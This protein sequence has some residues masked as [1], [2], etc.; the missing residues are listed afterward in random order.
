LLVTGWSYRYFARHLYEAL[1]SQLLEEAKASGNE[2]KIPVFYVAIFDKSGVY[3][4][5]LTP[6]VNEKALADQDL[7]SKTAGGPYQGVLTITDR[8]FGFGAV[9][10]PKLAPDTGVVVMRSEL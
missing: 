5:P 7:V 8:S 10:T 6:P 9:R 3:G 4:A 2:G 1:K